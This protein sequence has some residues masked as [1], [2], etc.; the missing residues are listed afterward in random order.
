LAVFFFCFKLD[1]KC[2]HLLVKINTYSERYNYINTQLG[3]NLKI[4]KMNKLFLML[5][6]SL[7]SMTAVAQN[8][9]TDGEGEDEDFEMME[10]KDVFTEVAIKDVPKKVSRNL[11]SGY[12]NGTLTKAFNNQTTTKYKLHLTTKEG[13]ELHLFMDPEG[14]WL[15]M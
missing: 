5:G 14:V 15:E 10:V 2:W 12:P 1:F 7:M 11:K 8:N 9:E 6:F 3:F 13:E 4:I